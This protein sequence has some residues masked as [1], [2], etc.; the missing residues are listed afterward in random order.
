M[1][2]RRFLAAL[3]TLLWTAV[4]SAAD[5][6]PNVVL[7]MADDVG[8]ECF[9]AYG[10]KQY[11]TPRLNRIADSGVKFTQAY[12]TPLCTPSRV[13]LMTGKSNVRNYA[14][15]G[16][17]I[18][19]EYTFADLFRAAGYATA[20]A[21]KWQ[22]QGNDRTQGVPAGHGFDRHLL[23]NTPIT[24]RLRFWNPSLDYNGRLLPVQEDDYGP[25]LTS[26]FLLDFI[27]QQRHRPFFVYYPMILVH[28]PFLP[29]PHSDDR[30][31][32]EQQRNFED[33]VAY[34]DYLVGKFE[35]KLD[36][37]DLAG[38]TVLIFTAD[39]GTHHNL[40]SA[41]EGRTIQGDKGAPTEAGTHVPLFVKAPGRVPGGRVIRDLIDF[42]DFFPTLAE[43][44]GLEIPADVQIDGR[45]FWPQLTGKDGDPRSTHFTYY[46][47]RPYAEEF[48]TP[49]QNPEVRYAHDGRY[50]L[51]ADGTLFDFAADP[52]E[53]SPLAPDAAPD[54]REKLKAALD[55]MPAHG[56][57][58]PEDAGRRSAGQPRPRWH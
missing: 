23:W 15:F 19:G 6:P 13:S 2:L 12:S 11:K 37:L 16:A 1:T 3:S 38:D 22:L 46:F 34:M 55:A 27:D 30:S 43:A 47:P 49:Y 40:S 10:S 21:G 57:R 18:P 24:T 39:N 25:D 42:S 28:S 9:G 20:V 26:K 53:Q 50:K 52:E 35:D 54:I 14:D 33:M 51:Y 4:A 48:N 8:Y 45:S 58:I 41:L 29:T 32:K 36:D 7:I 56:A 31:S 17:L 44:A 5:R